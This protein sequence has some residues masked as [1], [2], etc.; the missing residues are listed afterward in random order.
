MDKIDRVL[1]FSLFGDY[2]HFKTRYTTS[3]SVTHLVPPRHTIAGILGAIMGL[4]RDE[5]AN[6]FHPE[7][8]KIGL[9]INQNISTLRV[10]IKQLKIKSR[11]PITVTTAKIKKGYYDGFTQIEEHNIIPFQLLR[12]PHYTIYFS[13]NDGEVYNKLAELL[14]RHECIYPPSFGMAQFLADF[15]WN[16]E[17]SAEIINDS[18]VYATRSVAPLESFD[19]MP[20]PENKYH[21]D[22]FAY[23][24][25][26]SRQAYDFHHVVY[27]PSSNLIKGKYNG[28]D[29]MAL[30]TKINNE[31][32]FL[33]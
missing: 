25:D 9:T 4:E 23:Y 26:S 22:R 20:G 28:N 14:K 5:V 29:K 10:A 16:G 17:Y 15:K 1:S 18:G 21:I 27:D 32:I 24:M 19:I 2:G 11:G 13:H 6:I 12:N 31:F 33:W 30:L 8:S 3:S 7:I